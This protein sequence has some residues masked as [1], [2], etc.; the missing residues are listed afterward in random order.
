MREFIVFAVYNPLALS[1]FAA[2]MFCLGVI[3]H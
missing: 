2:V 3:T 1:I